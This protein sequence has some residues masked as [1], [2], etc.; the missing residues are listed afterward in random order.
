MEK[1]SD[2]K[3]DKRLHISLRIYFLLMFYQC[4]ESHKKHGS[5]LGLSILKR[6]LELLEGTVT[7]ISE[8]GEGTIMEVR[9]PR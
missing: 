4:D 9:V 1:H 6:I 8:N 7:C 2:K 3:V 5:G